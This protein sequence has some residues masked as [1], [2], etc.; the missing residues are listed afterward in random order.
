[1]AKNGPVRPCPLENL[2]HN[3]DPAQS[4]KPEI[5]NPDGHFE[6]KLLDLLCHSE[7]DHFENESFENGSL[8]KSVTSV[9]V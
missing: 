4:V 2:G 3:H 5:Y 8:G 7:N 6:N 1:M 9:T